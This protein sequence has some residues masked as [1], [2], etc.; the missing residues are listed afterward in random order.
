LRGR[1]DELFGI[2]KGCGQR[3]FADHMF[4]R[5][6]RGQG[7]FV[8][9][10]VGD[11]HVY[12]ID[13]VGADDLLRGGRT[14]GVESLAGGAAGF[15]TAPGDGDKDAAGPAHGMGVDRADHA[16][17]DHTAAWPGRVDH[18]SRLLESVLLT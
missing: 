12:D 8:M 10:M 4:T 1:H 14:G 6:Q 13:I 16:H 3:L 11:A 18:S 2:L 5:G 9:Q 7:Q 17:A 15:R